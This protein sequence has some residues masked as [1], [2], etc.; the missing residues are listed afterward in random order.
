MKTYNTNSDDSRG[1]RDRGHGGNRVGQREMYSAVCAD[2][3]D[4]C[5]VPFKPSNDKPIYCSRCFEKHDP[6][7]EMPSRSRRERLNAYDRNPRGGNSHD[8]REMF[9]T[10]CDKC[11]NKC[12]VPFKP[13]GDKPVFCSDC[14]SKNKPGGTA[15]LNVDELKAQIELLNTKMDKVIKALKPIM[16]KKVV[17]ED[18]EESVEFTE[19]KTVRAAEKVEKLSLK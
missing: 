12:E 13:S 6:R 16:P 7:G 18:G 1:V 5:K 9:S 19:K 15:A 3:G 2:C 11:G 4:D 14:Y 17:S 10:I 8:D